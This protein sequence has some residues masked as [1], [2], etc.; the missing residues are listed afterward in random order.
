MS[1]QAGSSDVIYLRKLAVEAILGVLP[2]ERSTPQTVIFDIELRTNIRPAAASKELSDTVDYAAVA[3]RVSAMTID[4]RYL[5]IESLAE[6]V[7]AMLLKQPGVAGVRVAIA[8]PAAVAN[9][10]AA[11]I[12]IYRQR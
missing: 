9:A 12:S 10:D 5:L 6:D 8:K 2:E 3:A 7:A 4:G 1:T 11:G